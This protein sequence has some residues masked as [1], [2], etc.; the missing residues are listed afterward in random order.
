[1]IP[2]VKGGHPEDIRGSSHF[3]RTKLNKENTELHKINTLQTPRSQNCGLAGDMTE[4]TAHLF[5]KNYLKSLGL[6]VS[7]TSNLH[8]RGNLSSDKGH[9]GFCF[10]LMDPYK[11]D[12]ATSLW[13]GLEMTIRIKLMRIERKQAKQIYSM[14]SAGCFHQFTKPYTARRESLAPCPSLTVQGAVLSLPLEPI[15]CSS[16]SPAIP[17]SP[18]HVIWGGSDKV[19]ELGIPEEHCILN[20]RKPMA[21]IKW[22]ISVAVFTQQQ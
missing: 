7:E 14:F 10:S 1:M 19:Q 16:P 11:T 6:L 22:P 21:S 9:P 20:H 18:F 12:S 3:Q 13:E 4:S 5:E 17:A 2:L 15:P 8:C